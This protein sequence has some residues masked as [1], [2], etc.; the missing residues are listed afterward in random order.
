M[1]KMNVVNTNVVQ[2]IVS[3]FSDEKTLSIGNVVRSTSRHERHIIRDTF[4]LY[5]E[6][7]C[8]MIKFTKWHSSVISF[9][10]LPSSLSIDSVRLV[11]MF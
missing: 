4:F 3:S 7:K 10:S 5:L 11:A 8:I 2:G 6:V 1:S 9:P